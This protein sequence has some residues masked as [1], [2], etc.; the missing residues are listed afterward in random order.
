MK[1]KTREKINKAKKSHKKRRGHKLTNI[2]KERELITSDAC[3]Y[4]KDDKRI[5]STNLT[6]LMQWTNSS[7]NTTQKTFK[8]L[9]RKCEFEFSIKGMEDH[10]CVS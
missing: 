7:K 10:G 3:R 4:Q 2:S 5:L 6:S 8:V 1:C 9:N